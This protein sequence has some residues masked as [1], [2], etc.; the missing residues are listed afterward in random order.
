MKNKKGR[1]ILVAIILIISLS[2]GIAIGGITWIIKDTPDISN[3]KGSSETT[4]I[5]SADGD[6]LTKLYRENRIYVSIDKIP[7]HLKEA[8][9]AIEDKNFYVH[10][11]V[12]FF[13]IVRAFVANIRAGYRAQGAST[14]T[15]QLARNALL[16]HRKTYYR[17]IQ[18]AYLA[19][20]FE[21]MY[22]KP[23]IL[24]MYL[25][26]IFMGHSAYGVEAAAQQ[27]F[28]KD[29]SELNLSESALIAGLPRAPNYYSPLRN[30]EAAKERRNIVLNRM[31]ELGYI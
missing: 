14:I 31:N 7:A 21:R 24:E 26:E 13:G 27:Y 18:E 29:V 3:Y 11:G 1:Y 5:Y 6:L 23:E 22:T 10:H 28:G 17:K 2:I 25:N 20:Q 12:D 8:I 30:P 4:I 16:H 9:V 19:L 15:R